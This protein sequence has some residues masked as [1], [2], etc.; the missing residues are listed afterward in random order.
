M[1][2]RERKYHEARK[3][4]KTYTKTY[5]VPFFNGGERSNSG[6]SF[7][8]LGITIPWNRLPIDMTEQHWKSLG[9]V[10]VETLSLFE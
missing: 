7:P 8:E 9:I 3:S 4:S 5:I 10:K 6:V 2:K 1:I